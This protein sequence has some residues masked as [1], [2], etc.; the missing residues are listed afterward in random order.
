MTECDQLNAT[1]SAAV[2]HG[3]RYRC[4]VIVFNYAGLSTRASSSDIVIDISGDVDSG[5]DDVYISHADG[6][7]AEAV[8]DL[9]AMHVSFAAG[10]TPAAAPEDPTMSSTEVSV[11][12]AT[13]NN[14]TADTGGCSLGSSSLQQL[15]SIERFDFILQLV[16][17]LGNAT[18]FTNGSAPLSHEIDVPTIPL[19][20][21]GS[22]RLSHSTVRGV[23][24]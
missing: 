24:L 16:P 21:L 11:C 3:R 15:S 12:N 8:A 23:K 10:L 18:N 2:I 19:G 7:R 13:F 4:D 17:P 1:L 20:M 5:L 14:A 6:R 22:A 9:S